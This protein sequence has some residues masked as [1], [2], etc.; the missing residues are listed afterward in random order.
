MAKQ[1]MTPSTRQ[2]T[3]RPELDL[4]K[5][6]HTLGF[7]VRTLQVRSFRAFHAEFGSIGLTPARHAILTIIESNP[8]VRQVQLASILGLQEPN[9]TKLVKEFESSGLVQRTRRP[10]DARAVGLTLT[11]A[12]RDFMTGIEPR[13]LEFDRQTV[14]SLTDFEAALL[15][16][17]LLKALTPS[18]EAGGSESPDI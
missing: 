2:T 8:G 12:G 17:L 6:E 11:D 9:M 1:A 13:L 5:I 18:W 15:K 3:K 4:S 7:L 10:E 16:Q 14:G